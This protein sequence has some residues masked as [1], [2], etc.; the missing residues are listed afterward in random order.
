MSTIITSIQT[1]VIMR[2][3]N[4]NRVVIIIAISRAPIFP[5]TVITTN[6]SSRWITIVNNYP[7]RHRHQ[8]IMPWPSYEHQRTRQHSLF[9]T[10][11]MY[12]SRKL[13]PVARVCKRAE[14]DQQQLSST[15][16]RELM[17]K[18]SVSRV[19]MKGVV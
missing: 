15:S 7:H 11:H 14:W 10:L 6:N 4:C 16:A 19:I 8:M 12:Q 3:N 18:K 5:L 17:E 1:I 13:S 9:E 2:N